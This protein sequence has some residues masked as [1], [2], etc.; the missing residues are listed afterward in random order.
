MKFIN[1]MKQWIHS[2]GERLYFVSVFVLFIAGYLFFFTSHYWM[3]VTSSATAY[4]AMGRELS[5]NGK[6]VTLI[7]WD[8][9]EKDHVMEVEIDIRNLAY[10]GQNQYQFSAQ[11]RGG[12]QITVTPVIE[13]EDWIILHLSDV[14]KRWSEILLWMDQKEYSDQTAG[15]LKLF[16]NINDVNLVDKIETKDW[17]GYRKQRFENQITL[18]QDQIAQYQQEIDGSQNKIQEIEAEI[19]RLDG[20]KKYQTMDEQAQ[21]DQSIETARKEIA[22]K[23]QEILDTQG[24]INQLT[25]KV[26]LIQK[27]MEEVLP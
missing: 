7:R 8:Y 6:G 23:E 12:K 17:A 4:T 22:K 24:E 20:T 25:E 21:T 11:S 2:Y 18:Y 27:Q 5:W 16:T 10:D 15:A 9:C 3:P 14:P 19:I 13:D 1:T 26:S